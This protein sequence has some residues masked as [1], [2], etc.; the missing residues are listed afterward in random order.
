MGE[1]GAPGRV[2]SDQRAEA[3]SRRRGGGGGGGIVGGGDLRGEMGRGEGKRRIG[4]AFRV[5][6]SGERGE[7]ESLEMKVSR[8]AEERERERGIGGEG[9]DDVS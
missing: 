4:S 7:R 2:N 6:E 3:E 8:S 9:D 1:G 5:E